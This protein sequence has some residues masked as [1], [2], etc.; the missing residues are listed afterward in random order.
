M[1]GA[2]VFGLYLEIVVDT[3]HISREEAIMDPSNMGLL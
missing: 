3:G 1:L 2:G